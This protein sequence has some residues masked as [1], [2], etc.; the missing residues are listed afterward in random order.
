MYKTY[1]SI[2]FVQVMRTESVSPDLS[3]PIKIR[4][5]KS[6]TPSRHKRVRSNS[7][8]K[9]GDNEPVKSTAKDIKDPVTAS[10][11][12]ADDINIIEKI[13]LTDKGK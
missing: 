1:L 12:L 2:S 4:S 3:S 11:R 5:P 9:S 7:K 10:T 8:E 13:K 6:R